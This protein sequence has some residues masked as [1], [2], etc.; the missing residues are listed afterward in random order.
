M[1]IRINYKPELRDGR[2]HCVDKEL[3]IETAT[4]FELESTAEEIG[5]R[6]E[7]D[8]QEF[9][10]NVPVCP[11]GTPVPRPQGSVFHPKYV[12][13]G[14]WQKGDPAPNEPRVKNTY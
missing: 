8:T 9:I 6:T 13:K 3:G 1:A 5:R 12:R 11:Y 2:W 14:H 4:Y 10:T 7:D